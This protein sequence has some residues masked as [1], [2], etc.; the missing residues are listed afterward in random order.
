MKANLTSNFG[1][2]KYVRVNEAN[3]IVNGMLK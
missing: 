3:E 2:P 1:I